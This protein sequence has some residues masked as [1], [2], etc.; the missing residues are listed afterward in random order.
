M[1]SVWALTVPLEQSVGMLLVVLI[2]V[3]LAPPYRRPDAA[4]G[5]TPA[6]MQKALRRGY[7]YLYDA[8]HVILTD[9]MYAYDPQTRDYERIPGAMD[10]LLAAHWVRT[11]RRAAFWSSFW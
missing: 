6:Q 1:Q 10:P 11:Q 9:G 5:I 3:A 4:S 2:L 7:A 8:H